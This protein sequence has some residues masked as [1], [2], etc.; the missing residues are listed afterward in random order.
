VLKCNAD[1]RLRRLLQGRVFFVSSIDKTIPERARLTRAEFLALTKLFADAVLPAEAP[2]AIPVYDLANLVLCVRL[3]TEQ[4]HQHW[5]ARL[6]LSY[7]ADVRSEPWSRVKALSRR[8]AN[9]SQDYYDTLQPVAELIKF[10]SER[11]A[12][13]VANPRKW[14]PNEPNEEARQSATGLV[15]REVYTRLRN[16]TT[17][18][19]FRDHVTDWIRAYSHRGY[20]STRPRAYDIRGIYETAAPIPGETPAAQSMD[21]LDVVREMF[22]EATKAVGAKVLD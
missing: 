20:G 19:L 13:F 21:F 10:L 6:G 15:A 2:I 11:L 3:A 16:L 12:G 7:R 1:R 5:N 14:E 8:F 18:R 4:F 17:E 22:R 9:Q